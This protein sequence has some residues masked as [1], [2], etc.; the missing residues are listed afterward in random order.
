[1][2]S[3]DNEND[4]IDEHLNDECSLF[5]LGRIE[6]LMIT[7]STG[8][9]YEHID[10]NTLTYAEAQEIIRDLEENDNPRDCREQF[11]KFLKKL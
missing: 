2:T 11:R 10:L 8:P 7:S 5:Q 9:N 3:S 1:M 4:W 6:Q